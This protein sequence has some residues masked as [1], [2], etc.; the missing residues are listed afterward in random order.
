MRLNR[1]IG[2]IGGS[3]LTGSSSF[4]GGGG[5][6][7]LPPVMAAGWK[8]QDATPSD[9]A[10]DPI[11]VSRGGYDTAAA[12]TTHSQTLYTT[13]RVRQAYPNHASFTTD[14]VALS[15]YVYSTDTISG[16]VN[17]SA[18]VSPKPIAAWV[19][20]H[21]RLVASSV[22]W[23]ICAFH[24]DA[25]L[26]T[27]VACVKVRGNDGTTQT[28]WQTVSTPTVSTTVEDANP[29]E[30]YTN[31][32]DVSSLANGAFWLEAEVYP[33]FGSAST[34]LKSEDNYAAVVDTR[35]FTRRWFR[36][37]SASTQYIAVAST[38]N[39][40]TGVTST[41]EA[42]AIA[43]PCLTVAGAMKEAHDTLGATDGA[44]D[45]VKIV[46]VDGVSLG[47]VV[48][49]GS[50]KQDVSAVTIT[51]ATGTTRANAIVTTSASWAPDFDSHTTINEGAVVF[52]DMTF[53]L[54]AAHSING[55]TG[56]R[57]CVQFVNCNFDANSQA[58][59]LR[60]GSLS[61]I[62]YF[63]C[64]FSNMPA[65]NTNPLATTGG[66]KIRMFRGCTINMNA[67]GPEA[68]LT[69]GNTISNYQSP[70]VSDVTVSGTIWYNNK[71]TGGTGSNAAISL[72]NTTG[73]GANYGA[74][75][76]VQNLVEWTSTT[77][78]PSIQLAPTSD[79]GEI[80]HAVVHHN[81]CA[82]Y[83]LYGRWNLFYDE[84]ATVQTNHEFISFK[85]NLGT[86]L[87]T[88]GDV[89]ATD[90]T[91]IGQFPFTHGVGCE[92]NYSSEAAAAASEMQSY[93]GIGSLIA[94]GAPLYT[95]NQATTVGPVAGA[96]G[97][98]YTLQGGSSALNILSGP[99]LK[100]DL[101]G[102]ARGSGTQDA[103][104]YA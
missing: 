34:V 7:I 28:S 19:M 17:S 38:G 77:S 54:G 76:V 59:S 58:S 88:K 25:R 3:R 67:R 60:G 92:G 36:K 27:Q 79:E 6:V 63:G 72:T 41:T 94:N 40:A 52:E 42:T 46:I 26:G 45:V 91:R 85:G 8:I 70:G 90:G 101:A 5:V 1:H 84:D 64:I 51:R 53:K 18:A 49:T 89:F 78:Y 22:V 2:R 82:G 39:D 87:N 32:L 96:G 37:S 98:V 15:D 75:A 35:E 102:S 65:S 61:D 23:E 68:W 103:G 20:P 30:V 95:T 56:V 69:L 44:L 47:T 9:L 57:L 14:E 24:R 93:P 83:D 97:G 11:T 12:L 29:I 71:Y 4:G 50:Y 104:C 86:Q 48:F 21:R 99:V 81:T 16:R 62:S 73:A 74:F 43:T 80:V 10:L 55:A 66:G 13:K 33:W 100:Y 31:T